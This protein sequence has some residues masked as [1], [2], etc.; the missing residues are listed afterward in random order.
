MEYVSSDWNYYTPYNSALPDQ[1]ARF[2]ACDKKGNKWVAVND[3]LCKIDSNNQWTVFTMQNSNLP[4]N[5]INLIKTD[6]DDAL[7]ISSGSKLFNYDGTT[8]NTIDLPLESGSIIDFEFDS[9]GVIW[10]AMTP[11]PYGPPIS[12]SYKGGGV[13]RYDGI[14]TLF[15]TTNAQIPSVYVYAVEIDGNQHVWIGTIAGLC[16]IDGSLFTVYNEENSGLASNSISSLCANNNGDIW[17]GHNLGYGISV[18]NENGFTDES[19]NLNDAL[20]V[21][22]NPMT[23]Y[24]VVELP[25]TSVQSIQ[26][27]SVYSLSGQ[28]VQ[29]PYILT[30]KGFALLRGNLENG[31]YILNVQTDLK[32]Y[33]AKIMVQ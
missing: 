8:W 17:I 32:S 6:P 14:F 24:V 16:K 25:Q 26:Q 18:Y 2:I 22:P 13:L 33:Q 4:T 19:G 31:L 11:A 20:S 10:F 30:S 7:W 23:D 27:I 28:E 3:A 21:F 1:V 12:P 29:C 9:S 5:N 15:D